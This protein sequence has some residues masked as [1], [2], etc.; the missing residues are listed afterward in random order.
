MKGLLMKYEDRYYLAFYKIEIF[1]IHY[2][3]QL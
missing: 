1:L 2:L 3:Q